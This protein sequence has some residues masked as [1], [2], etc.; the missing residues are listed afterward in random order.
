MADIEE[1]NFLKDL[2]YT[3][4]ALG[5]PVKEPVNEPEEAIDSSLDIQNMIKN[6]SHSLTS[7]APPKKTYD[8]PIEMYD[9]YDDIKRKMT[10]AEHKKVKSQSSPSKWLIIIPL[11]LSVVSIGLVKSKK[12]FDDPYVL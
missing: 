3:I 8:F 11:I 2:E 6:I 7:S 12:Q 10:M 4:D 1:E 9:V 5:A